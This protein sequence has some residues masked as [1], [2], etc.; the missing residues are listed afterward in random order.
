MLCHA[1]MVVLLLKHI[2][3]ALHIYFGPLGILHSDRNQTV[4]L[5]SALDLSIARYCM[6]SDEQTP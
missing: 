5:S 1:E 2:V 6:Y 3:L 4:S